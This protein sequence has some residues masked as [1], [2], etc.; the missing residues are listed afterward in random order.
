MTVVI[1]SNENTAGTTT[2]NN[3]V[4]RTYEYNQKYHQQ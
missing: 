3:N 4:L 2:G 1:G